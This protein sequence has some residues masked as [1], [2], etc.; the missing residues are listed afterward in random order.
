MALAAAGTTYVATCLYGLEGLL[1]DEVQDRL[2]V[3]AQR[4][5]CEVAF[6]Y[7]GDPARVRDLRLA[8]NVFLRLDRLRIGH[9]V[10]D[11]TSLAA[12][13]GRLPL[14]AWEDRAR[15]FHNAV[16]GDVSISVRRKGEHNFTYAQVEEVALDAVSRATGRRTTLEERPLEL[17]VDIHQ[18][19]CRLLGRL[20]V[21]PLSVRG[22]RKRHMRSATEPTL[23]AAMVR[24]T[25]PKADDLFLDPFCGTGTVPVERALTGGASCIVAGDVNARRLDWAR[26]NAQ[27][28]G[29]DVLFGRWD[30]GALPFPD[31][32]FSAVVGV[33]PQSHPATGLRWRSG[34]FAALLHEC[35][36][37]LRFDGVTVW[38]MQ[39]G[40]LF[41]NALKRVAPQW[42]PTRLPCNW[43]GRDWTIYRLRKSF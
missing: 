41:P 33:P 37:V 8:G 40:S 28:A 6:G 42:K 38:L 14:G 23:A 2:A 19:W 11:L 10:A 1:A 9:T 18:E 35:L 17:R 16:G 15:G 36:R 29:A 39:R 4:H 30:T 20:T 3:P 22:Y 21:R 24:L 27:A 7:E 25:E 32:T 26:T 5:W 12:R 13:L 31:R 34:Q 43:K